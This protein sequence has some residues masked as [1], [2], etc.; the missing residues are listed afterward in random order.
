MN[1]KLEQ[2]AFI[3]PNQQEQ[4][5]KV[6]EFLCPEKKVKEKARDKD[7]PNFTRMN[8]RI[9]NDLY[10]RLKQIPK[11][12]YISINALIVSLLENWIDETEKSLNNK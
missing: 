10:D 6:S 1:M 8:V 3:F 2:S 5:E 7:Y 11:R 9:P 4:Q 12:R